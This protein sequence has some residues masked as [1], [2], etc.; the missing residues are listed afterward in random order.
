MQGMKKSK[1]WIECSINRGNEN[2]PTYGTA[3][4]V[5]PGDDSFPLFLFAIL[6]G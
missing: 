5:W 4:E 3:N 1:K 6:I 2:R